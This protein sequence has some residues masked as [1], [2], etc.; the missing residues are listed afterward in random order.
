VANLPRGQRSAASGGNVTISKGYSVNLNISGSNI[1]SYNWSP[2]TGLSSTSI[3]NPIANPTKTTTYTVVVTNTQGISTTL[4]I[5]VTVLEDYNITPNNVISP[6]GDG[7]NDVWVVENLS[8][9]P[10]NEVQIF[11]KA[12]R[13]LYKVRNYQND[14]NG[15]LNGQV[16]HGGAYY[17]VINLGPG[18]KPKA[19]YITLFIN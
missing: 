2:S 12:G 19:G 18:T 8:A 3:S 11:D 6:N 9:Y 5:T 4:F 7:V 14:W 15:Q 16:L 1:V 17:Y 13:V 10:D